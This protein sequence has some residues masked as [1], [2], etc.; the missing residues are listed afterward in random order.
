MEWASCMELSRLKRKELQV[1]SCSYKPNL[2]F[3][4]RILIEFSSN[5][6]RLKLG[7]FKH[8][9]KAS[10]FPTNKCYLL[11]LIFHFEKSLFEMQA[12]LFAAAN[13]VHVTRTWWH[14][15]IFYA[16][17][18]STGKLWCWY[19]IHMM[20]VREF[21]FL[22]NRLP[23]HNMC[24]WNVSIQNGTCYAFIFT[25]SFIFLFS[26]IGCFTFWKNEILRIFWW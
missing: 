18:A 26:I 6:W 21:E 3:F 16:F 20:C 11:R 17:V 14:H 8:P 1:N 5:S 19:S 9:Q 23:C 25:V 22:Y 12:D 15:I 7:A 13:R 2:W 10:R 24:Y 4:H